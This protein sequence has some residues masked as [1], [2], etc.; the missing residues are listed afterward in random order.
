MQSALWTTATHFI[1]HRIYVSIYAH[2]SYS[3]YK[4]CMIKYAIFRL[5]FSYKSCSTSCLPMKRSIVCSILDNNNCCH[6]AILF[7]RKTWWSIKKWK[8][9]RST[10]PLCSP[11]WQMSKAVQLLTKQANVFFFFN[12]ELEAGTGSSV[13]S[14]QPNTGIQNIYSAWG[15]G[16]QC[17][18]LKFLLAF[19][20]IMLF[21]TIYSP[22]SFLI[23]VRNNDIRTQSFAKS[24]NFNEFE[25]Q[26]KL[27]VKKLFWKS[28]TNYFQNDDFENRNNFSKSKSKLF[29]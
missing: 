2:E 12:F 18:I 1:M 29:S 5:F 22:Q 24:F 21:L 16:T 9:S 10:H 3:V 7:G 14:A 19:T 25:N 23:D 11:S 20:N 13:E 8:I 6:N 26:I 15:F 17:R 4:V 28:N 27:L